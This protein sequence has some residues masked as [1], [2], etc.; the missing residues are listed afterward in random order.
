M[1]A[2]ILITSV[3]AVALYSAQGF[4]AG[5]GRAGLWTITTRVNM[6]DMPKM[7]PEQM[8]Q[9]K[10]AGVNMS[11][12]NTFVAQHCVSAQ[13]AAMD[14][15]PVG[16]SQHGCSMNN[17]KFVHGK[18]SA[19]MTCTGDNQATGHLDVTYDSDKHYSGAVRM[20]AMQDG[21]PLSMTNTFEGK[22]VSADCGSV[23]H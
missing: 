5:H 20:T 23:T 16:Q 18:M 8:A 21:K 15:P 6:P 19:D 2:A 11:G 12:S 13:E 22:W 10:A 7:S 3:L 9:M 14:R 4:A 17:Y 1:R